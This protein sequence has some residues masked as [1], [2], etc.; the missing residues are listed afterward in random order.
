[1]DEKGITQSQ[2]KVLICRSTQYFF[3]KRMCKF[4]YPPKR[5][6]KSR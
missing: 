5:Y 1:M 4:T 2:A 6:V 3:P